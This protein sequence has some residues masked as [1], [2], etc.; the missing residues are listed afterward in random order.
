MSYECDGQIN[1]TD[2]L[3]SIAPP[4][5]CEDCVFLE[6]NKC[7]LGKD[8]HGSK[9]LNHAD[10][11][12]RIKHHPNNMV[13]GEWPECMEWRPVNTFHYDKKKDKYSYTVGVGKDK[14]F[15]WDRESQV[16]GDVIAWR[17]KD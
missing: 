13:S 14:T 10:G 5:Y 16:A 3:K 7:G 4:G 2:Y 9:S 11:W 15:K 17:Y 6:D 12:H 8:C 1:L